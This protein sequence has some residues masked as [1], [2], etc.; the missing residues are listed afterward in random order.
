MSYLPDAGSQARAIDRDF[1]YKILAGLRPKY[2]QHILTESINQ[3]NLLP[4]F[5]KPE[6]KLRITPEYIKTLLDKP[7]ISSKL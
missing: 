3:R 4:K 7:W 1:A 6:T 5:L 2:F